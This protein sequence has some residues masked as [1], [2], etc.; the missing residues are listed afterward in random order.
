MSYCP[1]PDSHI[2]NNVKVVL[3]YYAT[4][5]HLDHAIYVD[6]SDLAAK[7]DLIALNTEVDKLRIN[8]LINVP[9]SWNNLKTKVDGSV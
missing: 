2:R 4:K 7:K 5:K 8:K 9:T 1:E 6:T 3:D